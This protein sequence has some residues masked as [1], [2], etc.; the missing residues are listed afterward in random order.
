[1]NHNDLK[2][3]SHFGNVAEAMMESRK[4]ELPKH[5]SISELFNVGSKDEEPKQSKGRTVDA[6]AMKV[7]NQGS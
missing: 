2:Y 7:F 3:L 6:P 4:K 1:M 5:N